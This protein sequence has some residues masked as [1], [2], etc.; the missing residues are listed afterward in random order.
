MYRYCNQIFNNKYICEVNV[1]SDVGKIVGD[2]FGKYDLFNFYSFLLKI[3]MNIEKLTNCR[4]GGGW[5]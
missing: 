3:M 5:W 4:S 1:T 2:A